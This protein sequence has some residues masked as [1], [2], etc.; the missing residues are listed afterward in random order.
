M[1]FF[2]HEFHELTRIKFV[3]DQ[4]TDYQIIEP[5]VNQH[6]RIRVVDTWAIV[7]VSFAG[8]HIKGNRY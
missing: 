7:A 2:C 1:I 5:A 4:S 3:A 6:C 8:S